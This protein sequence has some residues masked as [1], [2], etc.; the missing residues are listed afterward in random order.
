[1]T[2]KCREVIS[3]EK[4]VDNRNSRGGTGKIA[5]ENEL[6]LAKESFHKLKEYLNN[7]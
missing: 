5:V 1:L 2:P 7:Y 3:I 6:K 4:C